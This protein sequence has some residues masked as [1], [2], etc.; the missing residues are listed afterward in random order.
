MFSRMALRLILA[1]GAVG[2]LVSDSEVRG[3]WDVAFVRRPGCIRCVRLHLRQTQVA[4]VA[5]ARCRKDI[6]SRNRW[7]ES[8]LGCR[9]ELLGVRSQKTILNV[10]QGARD[11][12][13]SRLL[14][15]AGQGRTLHPLFFSKSFQLQIP[16]RCIFQ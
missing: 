12:G 2:W 3:V 5:R 14:P 1:F 4:R 8:W 9:D 15:V 13:Y 7:K 10:R 6:V 11:A 16:Y